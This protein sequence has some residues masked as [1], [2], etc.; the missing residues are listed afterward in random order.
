M[1]IRVWG[2]TRVARA[3]RRLSSVRLP[4]RRRRVQLTPARLTYRGT[5]GILR[6][7]ILDLASD[8]V[9]PGMSGAAVLNLRSGGGLR[10][11]RGQQTPRPARRC[12]GHPVVGDRHRPGRR[13]CREPG[14]PPAADLQWAAAAAGR[15]GHGG[16]RPR[17]A[18]HGSACLGDGPGC[19]CGRASAR[20][21]ISY[22]HDDAAH[23]DRVRDFW[24]FL[25]AQGIDAR[26]DLPA[27]EQ[28]QDWAQWMTRQVRDADRVLVIASPEYKRRAEGDAAPGEGRGV[29]W[30][31]RLIR[32]RV[33]RRPAGRAAAGA[34]GGAAGL[35]GRRHPA[36]AGARRRRRTTW[37]ASTRWRARRSCCGC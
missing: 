21:F 36:V 16:G 14:L 8:T 34:A 25:R 6:P 31:A 19:R 27:A 4:A 30:E 37:S 32:E 24:L 5:K 13:A 3:G 9:K 18:R 2:L 15:R 33:L 22:A 28:R 35:L 20:V 11:D 1:A 26:L 10:G 7:P 23:E 29:Q 12:A 17:R